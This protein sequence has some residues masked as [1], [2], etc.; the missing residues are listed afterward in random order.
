MARDVADPRIGFTTITKVETTPDLRH[1]KVWVSVIGQ[2]AERRGT[3]AALQRAMPF[4]R[5][6]LGRALR[7]KRIP[8]LHVYLDETA[9]RGTRVLQLLNELGEGSAHEGD[10]PL[11]ETLPTPVARRASRR[12]RARGAAVRGDPAEAARPPPGGPARE[13]AG[14]EGGFPAATRPPAMTIDLGPYLDTVPDAVV[15]RLRGARRV[16]AVS[17]ENPDADTLGATLGV[18]RIVE[19]LGGTAD[20]VCTDPVPPLYDF[21]PEVE[22]FRTDPDDE[23]PLRPAGRLR[24]RHARPDR[25]RPRSTCRSCSIDCPGSSSTTT[26]RTP[27][28]ARPT[29]SSPT[30]RRPARWSRSSR[31]G[32]ACRSTAATARWPRPSWPAS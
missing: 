12:R 15:E 10:L 26:P 27:R 28:R 24:L 1:A 11:G 21:L 25:R 20:A 18:V 8:D 29:G 9:E 5:H 6:E 2:P 16:L 3:V 19:S 13:R 31:R 22:R 32:S 4:V 17:H 23:A 7:I 14:L 30:P